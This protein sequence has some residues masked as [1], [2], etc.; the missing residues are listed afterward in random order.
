MQAAVKAAQDRLKEI[1][2]KYKDKGVE[3]K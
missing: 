2:V 1:L 3:L